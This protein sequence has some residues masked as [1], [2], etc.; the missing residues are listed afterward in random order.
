MTVFSSSSPPAYF[1]NSSFGS[2]SPVLFIKTQKH[3]VSSSLLERS[4][5]S[6]IWSASLWLTDWLEPAAERRDHFV[7]VSLNHINNGL[8]RRGFTCPL[9]RNRKQENRRSEWS[10][11]CERYV[12]VLIMTCMNQSWRRLAEP[13]LINPVYQGGSGWCCPLRCRRCLLKPPNVQY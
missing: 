11:Q 13:R 8:V 5:C 6:N 4:D 10:N 3:F 12:T 9:Y 1:P 7:F 2:F